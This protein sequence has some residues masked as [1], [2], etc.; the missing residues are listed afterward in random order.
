MVNLSDLKLKLKEIAI[1]NKH[2]MPMQCNVYKRLSDMLRQ[3]NYFDQHIRL[4]RQL[5]VLDFTGQ[6]L[7]NMYTYVSREKVLM[8]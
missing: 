7:L 2:Y 8:Q 3:I 6:R 1:I 4:E 5:K